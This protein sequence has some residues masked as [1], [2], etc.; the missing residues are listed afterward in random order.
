MKLSTPGLYILSGP[1]G[2]G[3]STWVRNNNLQEFTFSTDDFRQRV[4]GTVTYFSDSMQEIT[5]PSARM[6][7]LV[8]EIMEKI[9]ETRMKEGLL[10]LVDSTAL[11]DTIRKQWVKLAERYHR[12]AH[13]LI[14]DVD[15]DTCLQGNTRRKAVIPAAAVVSQWENFQ[16]DSR[17]AYTLVQSDHLVEGYSLPTLPHERF[18][19]I[20]D[21][22]GLRDPLFH[23]LG[24]LGYHP[25]T[26][27]HPED[28][29]LLVLGDMVDRGP[30]SLEILE[31]AKSL[32]ANGHLFLKGN[33]EEKLIKRVKRSHAGQPVAEGSFAGMVTLDAFLEKPAEW[34]VEFL[35]FLEKLP[36]YVTYQ[37][38]VFLH[39]DVAQ[40]D[41]LRTLASDMLYGQSV[42]KEGRSVDE[43]YALNYQKGI[44]R[45]R[46]VHGH[47]PHSSK[48]DT[49]IV[50]SLEKKQVHA[51]GHLAS[52]ALDR[53]CAL[54]TLSD[55]HSLVVLQPGNYNFKE[56]KKESLM[57]KEGLEA[58]VKDKLVVKCQDENN[59]LTL[60]KYHRKVLFDKLWDRDPLLAKAR[61]LVLDRKGKI[62]Q[63][64]FDR[65]F[66]YGE[67][68]CLLTADRAMS[69]TA[70]DKLNGYMVAVTQH[71][72]LRKKLLMSTNGS[73][74]PGSPY[75]LMA[76]N[77]LLGSVEKIQDFVDETGLTLLFEILDPADP[78]IVHY[79]D[80][81]FGAWLIGARGHTLEDQPLEEAALDDMALL[82]GLRRPGW[83]T[84]TLGEILE[85]NQTEEN[86]EGWM[87]RKSENGEYLG[88]LK[89]VWY[90]NVKFLSRMNNELW[91]R[92]FAAPHI[93]KQR[94]DEEFY[95]LVD[96]L[97][98]TYALEDIQAL[99]GNER[100]S[101]LQDLLL[102]QA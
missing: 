86:F 24:K 97:V 37:D 76:Q 18:D 88:K 21:I 56:R 51:N 53:L 13:I 3:K 61:G 34:Q 9:V 69:V 15:L 100:S 42:P 58:L 62:V 89:T 80:A 11:T 81:W 49:S 43:L 70:T 2:S 26:G 33:H 20:G 78:H 44:N 98:S 82:L 16:K 46:L 85:R 66:N 72:Y 65:C 73:L 4:A 47:I 17:F 84:T 39:A 52:I 29:K 7:E 67:N 8:F 14:F 27:A 25:E 35:E 30:H 102:K 1:S 99:S 22:H 10:T 90:M 68:G 36:T 91:A 23:L 79:D 55:M 32:Q 57:L 41:P 64:G 48:A 12:S 40:F 96:H 92:L 31:W 6:D 87:L 5:N 74:D 95:P 38:L 45:F 94:V 19:I 101:L 60:Y 77:H 93:F 59:Q 75:L 83:Q 71:P 63:R 54:P 50:L 28:R